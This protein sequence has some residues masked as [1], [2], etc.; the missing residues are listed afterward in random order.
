MCVG[1]QPPMFD[2]KG[3]SKQHIAQF[4]ETWENAK[5]REDLLVK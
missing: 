3:N 2:A 4:V 5:T 1:Y